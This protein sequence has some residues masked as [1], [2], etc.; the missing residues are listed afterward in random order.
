[1]PPQ[2]D[3]CRPLQKICH[4]SERVVL[5]SICYYHTKTHHLSDRDD[6]FPAAS[7]N[8]SACMVRA[9]QINRHAPPCTR[10][11]PETT[12]PSL[13]YAS[14]SSLSSRV[15]A[16]PRS[17]V[18]K[19]YSPGAVSSILCFMKLYSHSQSKSGGRPTVDR[20]TD[21]PDRSVGRSVAVGRSVD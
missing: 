1:M 20:P 11:R 3:F 12:H 19:L 18:M 8:A 21:R 13:P 9:V 7:D 16:I 4:E 6:E 15:T 5:R 17:V 14:L 2:L 10:H